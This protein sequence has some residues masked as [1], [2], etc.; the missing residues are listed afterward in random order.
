VGK[1][2]QSQAE[3]VPREY[4][5]GEFLLSVFPLPNVVFFPHTRLPLHIFEQRY[6]QMVKD[7]LESDQR[8]GMVL[9]RPGWEASYEGSPPVHEFGTLGAIEHVV[10]TEDGRYHLVL[11][12]KVRFRIIEAVAETPYR[13]FR[14]IAVPEDRYEPVQAYAER[15]WLV[16]LCR[17]YLHYLPGSIDIP[18]LDNVNLDAITNA[19]IMSLDVDVEEKQKLLEMN[20]ILARA[21]RVGAELQSRISSLQ[22]LDAYRSG[23]DPSRN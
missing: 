7:A 13:V 6:R 2:V 1:K 4:P 8:I 11:G 10:P 5:E 18:E 21:E 22:F 23:Q 12:G 19:L 9:L 15:E 16:D 17:Q 20:D 14:V 3:S